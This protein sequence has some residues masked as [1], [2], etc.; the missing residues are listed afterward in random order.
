MADYYYPI[1]NI[2]NGIEDLF[3]YSNTITGNWFSPLI[4]MAI[5]VIMFVSMK[6]YGIRT[7][8][9]FVSSAFSMTIVSYL[10]VLIPGFLS[11][12]V[13]AIT[14]MITAISVLFLYKTGSPQGGL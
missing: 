2:T 13:I 1:P 8:H 12:E 14:T 3:I 9:A 10:M 7:E 4:L 11:P 5:F 6:G